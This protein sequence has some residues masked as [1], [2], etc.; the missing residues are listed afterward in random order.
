MSVPINNW[1]A[2]KDWISSNVI[3]GAHYFFRGQKN[4]AWGLKTS[5][6]RFAEK[7]NIS[8][9]DYIDRIIPDVA[10]HV[11]GSQ[12]EKIDISTTPLLLDFLGK[13]QH[14][15]FPTPMLDWTMSPY[16]AAYFAFKDIDPHNHKGADH[17][18]IHMF[19]YQ[20]WQSSFEQ[21]IDLKD[22]RQFVSGY[23]PSPVN[24]SRMIRQMAVT[25]TTN[26]KDIDVYINSTGKTFLYR[27]TLPI[28]ER[29][30]VMNELN[31]MGINSM[32]M[33]A[34]FDGVCSAMKERHFN[35]LDMQTFV[36]PPPNNLHQK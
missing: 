13:L 34:G 4:P 19:Y 17:V 26:V 36:P 7:P 29:R 35:N 33:Y 1:K 30:L 16:I 15:G 14:H 8:M 27:A 25:T 24:N 20:L 9:A 11:S 3:G 10:H 32:T 6:H 18:V 5:F 23:T 2:Y 22:S 31:L 28:A 21:I 12:N